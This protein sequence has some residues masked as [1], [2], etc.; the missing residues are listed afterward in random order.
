MITYFEVWPLR[1]AFLTG[2]NPFMD[3]EREDGSNNLL[4]FSKVRFRATPEPIHNDLTFSPFGDVNPHDIVRGGIR[5]SH[6]SGE[7]LS[8]ILHVTAGI[9]V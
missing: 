8:V 5:S 3:H 7:G 4:F 6:M 1:I 9:Y 2:H